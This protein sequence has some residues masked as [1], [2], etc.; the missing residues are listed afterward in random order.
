[1]TAAGTY[2]PVLSYT[3]PD[4]AHTVELNRETTSLGRTPGQHVVLRDGFVSRQHASILRRDNKYEMV[5]VGSTHGTFLNGVRV[6]RAVLQAGDI[7]QL[8]SLSAPQIRFDLECVGDP[9]DISVKPSDSSSN[10][11]ADLLSS[12]SSMKLPTDRPAAAAREMEQLNFLLTAARQ[13]NAGDGL[14]DILRA[15]LQ[16]TLQLTGV[17][18]G[19]VFL[20]EERELQLA[21]GL[22]RAGTVI[23]E[24]ATV[25]RSAIQR[26]VESE[27]SFTISDTLAD[28][29]ASEWRSVVI[30]RIRSIYCI[31]LRKRSSPDEPN[32]LLGLLYLDSQVA[33]GNMSEVDHLLLDAVASE[34]ATLVHNALLADSESKARKAREELAIAATIHRGLMSIELPVTPYAKL[35]ANSVPCL[36]IG[37]DFF[38]ALALDDCVCVTIADVSGKGVSAAIVAATLQGIIHA[39]LQGRQSLPEIASQI[40]QFLCSRKVGKYVTCVM[41][42]L[43]PDGGVE[44]INCGHVLP[45]LISGK[46]VRLLEESNLVAGLIAT[47]E[48]ASTRITLQPGERILLLT[49]GVTEAENV[50]GEELGPEGLAALAIGSSVDEILD[51]A[52]KFYQ[53]ADAPDDCTAVEVCFLC[54]MKD[55]PI[56]FIM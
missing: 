6:K 8:G 16:L 4:G 52:I 25:S 17:E 3:D 24:D 11:V 34:A 43:F 27:G 37:G 2:V 53:P 36:C 40:N 38:D 45:L 26:A 50:A 56:P 13:L 55:D 9:S 20:C 28:H 23:R 5:D 7:L 15:L 49:D 29:D 33:P 14:P 42:K 51:A 30:N 22:D 32:R 19:F 47:A 21:L 12:F 41:L 35:T 54:P 46:E 44:Y 31:P 18:R 39:Q 1:M 10:S 48:Y